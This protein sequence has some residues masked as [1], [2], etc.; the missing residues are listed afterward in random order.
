MKAGEKPGYL[1]FRGANRYDSFTYPQSGFRVESGRVFLSKIG[2]VGAV[3]HRPL[4]GTIK[5]ATVR[6]SATGKWFVCFSCEVSEATEP[7]PESM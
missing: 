2:Y 5:T 7:L 1:R 6:K 3:I 4:E